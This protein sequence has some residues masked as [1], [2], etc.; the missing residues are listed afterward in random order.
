MIENS[1]DRHWKHDW[2]GE[3][4]PIF[5]S[6][7]EHTDMIFTRCSQNGHIEAVHYMD[8]ALYDGSG[9]LQILTEQHHTPAQCLRSQENPRPSIIQ[10]LQGIFQYLLDTKICSIKWKGRNHEAPGKRMTPLVYVMNVDQTNNLL[11]RARARGV[12][13][14]IFIL[15]CLDDSVRSLLQ[16]PDAQNIWLLP[17]NMRASIQRCN[18]H[19]NHYSYVAVKVNPASEIG[20]LDKQFK[21]ALGTGYF[22]AAWWG[23]LVGIVVGLAG[24]RKI[25]YK[26]HK[27]K[28]SW[29]GVLSNMGVW[30]NPDSVDVWAACAPVTRAHPVG[31]VFMTWNRQFSISMQVHPSL[32]S[33]GTIAP[34]LLRLLRQNL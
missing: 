16:H 13:L 11:A 27:K 32:D 24:M 2:I 31:V 25:I 30:G 15:K 4:Y 12:S 5:Y 6:L 23:L 22:W 1:Y 7:G 17:V 9:A 19:S 14:S 34:E 20:A 10:Q 18:P 21:T 26:Y 28:H 29:T 3:W 8:H 33:D